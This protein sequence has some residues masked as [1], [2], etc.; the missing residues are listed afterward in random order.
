MPG[1]FLASSG[2]PELLL[3]ILNY[4]ESPQD[5][6]SFA[7]TCRFMADVWHA[8]DAGHAAVWRLLLR[9]V[10]FAEEALTVVRLFE[11]GTTRIISS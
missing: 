6:L 3:H 2:P 1:N 10:P 9:N 11:H 5:V 8:N 7:L 4:S